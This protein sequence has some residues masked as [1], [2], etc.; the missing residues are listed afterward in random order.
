MFTRSY[1][2]RQVKAMCPLQ[3]GGTGVLFSV[4]D[5]DTNKCSSNAGLCERVMMN[6]INS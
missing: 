4:G 5:Q 3:G 2:G 6:T 1:N